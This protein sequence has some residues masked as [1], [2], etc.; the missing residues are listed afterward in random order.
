VREW[1]DKGTPVVQGAPSSAVA[2]CFVEIADKLTDVIATRNA[3]R[4]AV[5]IDR[6]GGSG[7]RRLPVMKG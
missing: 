1:G 4:A 3:P 7:H 6:S 5:V 2:K